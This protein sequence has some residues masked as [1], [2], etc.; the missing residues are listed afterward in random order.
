M[1]CFS[2]FHFGRRRFGLIPVYS[3]GLYISKS[4][5]K[6]IPS[7]ESILHGLY[8]AELQLKFCR[9]VEV[10]TMVASIQEAMKVRVDTEQHNA[11][12]NFSEALKDLVDGPLHD[13]T[14]LGFHWESSVLT[15]YIEE[16]D[17]P[18]RDLGIRSEILSRAVFAVY[19]DANAVVP[20][21]KFVQGLSTYRDAPAQ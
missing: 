16:D 21:E 10:E 20:R 2:H 19:L 7:P 17:S 15:V 9:K 5:V 13:G 12:D 11:V 3:V 1:F 6:S 14:T 8:E 4:D 18:R